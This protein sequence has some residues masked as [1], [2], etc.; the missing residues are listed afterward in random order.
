VTGSVGARITVPLA[1][2]IGAGVVLAFAV[3]ASRLLPA[4]RKMP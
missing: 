1:V 4:V 2:A 3:A